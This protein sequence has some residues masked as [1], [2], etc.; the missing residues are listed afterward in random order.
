MLAERLSALDDKVEVTWE[1]DLTYGT[2]TVYNVDSLRDTL[3]ILHEERYN[4]LWYMYERVGSNDVLEF[5]IA[6]V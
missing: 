3:N 4:V 6:K 1:V 2:V 5:T